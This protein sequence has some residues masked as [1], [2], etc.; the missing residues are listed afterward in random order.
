M[1]IL[2][3]CSQD[4]YINRTASGHSEFPAGNASV[5]IRLHVKL[6][7]NAHAKINLQERYYKKQK[8][9]FKL[10]QNGSHASSSVKIRCISAA[11]KGE[12]AISAVSARRPVIPQDSLAS[13]LAVAVAA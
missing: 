2:E 13:Y 10:S 7:L 4:I 9:P 8:A 3:F 12:M 5:Y 6:L 11:L 1:T